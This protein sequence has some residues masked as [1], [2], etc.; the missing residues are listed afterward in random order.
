MRISVLLTSIS[1]YEQD[2][3]EPRDSDEIKE[4]CRELKQESGLRPYI[5]W[6]RELKKDKKET[7][8]NST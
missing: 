8:T 2:M 7:G 4:K 6:G 3:Q 5:H 1:F